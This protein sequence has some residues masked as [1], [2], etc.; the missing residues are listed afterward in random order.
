[1]FMLWK[2]LKPTHYSS[3]IRTLLMLLP[4]LL[5]ILILII[6]PLFVA[7]SFSLK[8]DGSFSFHN[9]SRFFEDKVNLEIFFSSTG[10]SFF[11]SL[12][13]IIV[14]IPS[15]KFITKLPSAGRILFLGL[16]TIPMWINIILKLKS[17]NSVFINN[18]FL[19]EVFNLFKNQD[20]SFRT[21]WPILVAGQV[22]IYLPFMIIPIYN[23]M[24]KIDNNLIN[25]SYDLGATKNQ[26]FWKIIIPM[27]YPGIKL[28][29]ALVFLSA[30][31]SISFSSILNDN[32]YIML[33]ARI[34]RLY[35][36]QK[37]YAAAISILSVIIL[38][39]IYYLICFITK[40]TTH[41]R[42]GTWWKRM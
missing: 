23:S 25:A 33:G 22:F 5:L 4:Y 13:C 32:N 41:S 26:T 42:K 14:A 7:I 17:F 39:I 34:S 19:E 35:E 37:E 18:G 36:S 11:S 24:I 9:F 21:S 30:S 31:T 1:M 8:N 28:G 29:F 2:K 3:K 15:A 40:K 38:L 16:I 6:A 20:Y 10:I 12:I 27:L